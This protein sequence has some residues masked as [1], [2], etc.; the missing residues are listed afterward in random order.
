MNV[1]MADPRDE[2][3]A[4]VVEGLVDAWQRVGSLVVET[5]LRTRRGAGGRS[6]IDHVAVPHS[7]SSRCS[8]ART[9][10]AES[11][12]AWLDVSFADGE[13]GHSWAR[14]RRGRPQRTR[15]KWR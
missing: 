10:T 4:E 9:W 2:A 13:N 12:H 11:D 5:D 14:E 15:R 1:Q 6:S 8:V 7:L 3:E